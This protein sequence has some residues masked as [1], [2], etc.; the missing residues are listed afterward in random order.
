MKPLNRTM[1]ELNMP[2]DA[3]PTP[4]APM[5]SGTKPLSFAAAVLAVIAASL[6]AHAEELRP[7][8]AKSLHLGQVSGVVYFTIEEEGYQVVATLANSADA[9]VRFQ[10]TLLPGQKMVVSVPD[11][12][13][14]RART[15]EFSRQGDHLLVEA[16]PLRDEDER[17]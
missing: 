5:R 15:A 4:P 1:K 10:S 13:G 3:A 16:S 6:A 9:P 17:P 8:Q 14:A 12:V 7:L 11:S 2:V